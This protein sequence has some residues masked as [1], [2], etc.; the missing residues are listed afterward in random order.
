[1]KDK[2][3]TTKEKILNSLEG[4]LVVTKVE[5]DLSKFGV[6]IICEFIK[7]GKTG[8]FRY[9][10][11]KNIGIYYVRDYD[12]DDDIEDDIHNWVEK[13]FQ[14]KS[15]ISLKYNGKELIK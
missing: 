8:I 4:N 6:A 5:E 7:D 10:W 12:S 15:T 14:F 9:Y 1:M 2:N 3:I 13:H 11:N